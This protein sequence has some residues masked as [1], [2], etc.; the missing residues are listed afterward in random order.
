MLRCFWT[1]P[2]AFGYRISRATARALR[3]ELAPPP[4]KRRKPQHASGPSSWMGSYTY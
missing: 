2:G 3:R 4:R 1:L